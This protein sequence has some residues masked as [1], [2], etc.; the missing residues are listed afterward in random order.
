MAIT[1]NNWIVNENRDPSS[2][3]PSTS[4]SDSFVSCSFRKHELRRFNPK[5]RGESS[6]TAFVELFHLSQL[7]CQV[8]QHSS[9]CTFVVFASEFHPWSFHGRSFS[10]L[11][12]PLLRVPPGL[13]KHLPGRRSHLTVIRSPE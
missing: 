8:G 2:V 5:P 9:L 13:I 10:R 3:I 11:R 1:L 4:E 7:L 6:K 12:V